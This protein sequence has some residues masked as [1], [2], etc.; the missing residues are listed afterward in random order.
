MQ[1]PQPIIPNGGEH[2]AFRVALWAGIAASRYAS[3]N[4]SPHSPLV[5]CVPVVFRSVSVGGAVGNPADEINF[6]PRG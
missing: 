5:S 1:R 4:P 6:I 2:S 3:N